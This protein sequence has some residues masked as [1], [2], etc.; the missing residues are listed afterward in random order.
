MTKFTEIVSFYHSYDKF[1][2]QFNETEDIL[3]ITDYNG[4]GVIYY[5]ISYLVNSSDEEN[6]KK[7][8]FI[9]HHP[10]FNI[11]EKDNNGKTPLDFLNYTISVAS[12][13]NFK[14]RLLSQFNT[15]YEKQLLDSNVKQVH[16][17]NKI[18]I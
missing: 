8:E 10:K 13:D 16:Q 18:K 2:N 9:L 5:F 15:V 6:I 11:L 1:I 17:Q 7:I 14:N 3:S 12:K 4:Q